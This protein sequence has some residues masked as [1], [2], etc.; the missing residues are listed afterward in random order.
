M[1]ARFSK[2]RLRVAETQAEPT[3][4]RAPLDMYAGICSVC[5]VLS[6]FPHFGGSTRESYRCSD[7]RASM[8]ER[9]VA[10]ALMDLY[11]GTQT[12]LR[13]LCRTPQFSALAIYEP[14]VSGPHRCYMKTLPGYRHSSYR[15]TRPL[16]TYID[17]VANQDLQQLTYE[18]ETFDV[19]VTSD[20]LEHVRKPKAAF[21]EI[22]RVLKP[23]GCHVFTVPLQFPMPR[24]TRRRVD[25]SSDVDR[26]ILAPVY[27]GDGAD[28]K[29]L[30]YTD[31]GADMID[32]LDRLGMETRFSFVDA[33]NSERRKVLVF[34]SCKTPLDEARC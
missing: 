23:G 3:W 8:R 2:T 28:G 30:V 29:S 26:W 6:E 9:G 12:C 14:G 31:F 22:R 27:H 21:E 24:E 32:D 16:G 19:V 34:I 1:G 15:G 17:G 13:D 4:A 7:C 25:T 10:Q 5:G 11:G 18:S 20:V 33:A